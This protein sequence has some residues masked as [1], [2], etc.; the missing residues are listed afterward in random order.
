MRL[1]HERQD[2]SEE[3]FN[4]MRGKPFIAVVYNSSS[5]SWIVCKSRINAHEAVFG[6]TKAINEIVENNSID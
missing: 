3:C 4:I 1:I 2:L 5:D 6:M